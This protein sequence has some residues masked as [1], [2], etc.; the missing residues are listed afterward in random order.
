MFYCYSPHWSKEFWRIWSSDCF[1]ILLTNCLCQ[2][3]CHKTVGIYSLTTSCSYR[4]RCIPA[5]TFWSLLDG[6]ISV[7]NCIFFIET[8]SSNN[9]NLTS[10][11]NF[12][13]LNSFVLRR[14]F[15]FSFF[16]VVLSMKRFPN[17]RRKLD[18][19]SPL[20]FFDVNDSGISLSLL[21][22]IKSSKQEK[23]Y[24]PG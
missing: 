22:K 4:S 6:L 8:T 20:A 18:Y 14:K 12:Y 5:T 1:S 16:S 17:Q 7:L 2:C 13:R 23:P 15:N 3:F 24:I 10:F 11:V 19:H 21:I 9:F